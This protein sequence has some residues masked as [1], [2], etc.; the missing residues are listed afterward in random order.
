MQSK[1]VA[2]RKTRWYAKSKASYDDVRP[3]AKV[4]GDEKELGK[5]KQEFCPV[6]KHIDLGEDA[7]ELP[8]CMAGRHQ[9]E[10]LW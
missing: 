5:Y 7:A 2:S 10:T 9:P 3:L 8:W 1:A 4:T 6:H